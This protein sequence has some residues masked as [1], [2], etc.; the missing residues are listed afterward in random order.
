MCFNMTWQL[1]GSIMGFF[2]RKMKIQNLIKVVNFPILSHPR[3]FSYTSLL[4]IIWTLNYNFNKHVSEHLKNN[5]RLQKLE[6]SSLKIVRGVWERTC[7]MIWLA[8]KLNFLNWKL[9]ICSFYLLHVTDKWLTETAQNYFYLFISAIKKLKYIPRLK[10][11]ILAT[12][13][14]E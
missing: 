4:I 12:L 2:Q 8:R 3:Y 5:I 10:I 11:F 7:F 13:N 1:Y 9:L 14:S 6:N